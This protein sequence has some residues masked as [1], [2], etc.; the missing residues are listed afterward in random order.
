MLMTRSTLS[1]NFAL[2]SE[3][4][5]VTP[6]NQRTEAEPAP[7]TNGTSSPAGK[8]A[9]NAPK[10]IVPSMSACGL[11]QVTTHAFPAS[12]R[13]GRS[14]F[15]RLVSSVAL[16]RKSP[17]PIQQTITLPTSRI[18]SCSQRK[19]SISAPTP[20]KHASISVTSKK[21]TMSAVRYARP[22]FC[23]SAELMTNR[24]CS[25]MGATYAR[26]MVSPCK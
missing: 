12:F 24:F 9:W 7:S 20:K 2:K 3:M 18:A 21:V 23:V 19:R 14:T 5:V 6:K 10:S 4:S 26:P 15:A 16:L 8:E 1:L 25:P 17:M 22:R 11:N 13:I